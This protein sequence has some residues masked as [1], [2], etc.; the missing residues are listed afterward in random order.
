MGNNDKKIYRLL[1][2]TLKGPFNMIWMNPTKPRLF[3]RLLQEFQMLILNPITTEIIHAL[4]IIL[5]IFKKI[6]WI[7]K[8]F[9]AI[10]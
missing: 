2:L 6:S 4:N 8:C 10:K 5:F 9:T 1:S 3:S 7:L